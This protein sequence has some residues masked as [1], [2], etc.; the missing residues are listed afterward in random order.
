MN[1]L[2]EA[3]EG[4]VLW[5]VMLNKFLPL[6]ILILALVYMMIALLLQIAI[7]TLGSRLENLQ[8]ENAEAFMVTMIA[9]GFQNKLPQ[10]A[11]ITG[12]LTTIVKFEKF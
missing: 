9:D 4:S 6:F 2:E 12:G 3:Q 10:S 8:M 5:D 1:N 7:I 11:E